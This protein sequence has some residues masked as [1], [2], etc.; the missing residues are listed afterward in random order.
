V[1]KNVSF[2]TSARVPPAGLDHR[3]QVLQDLSGLGREIAA[4]HHP[5]LRVLRDLARDDRNVPEP[6]TF[7][8]WL[9]EG[10]SNV[11]FAQ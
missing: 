10:E 1:R 6:V 5:A 7:T 8:P 9:Y 3:L 4:A 11:A 2:T